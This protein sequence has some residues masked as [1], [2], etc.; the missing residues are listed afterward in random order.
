MAN[1]NRVHL[2][3]HCTRDPEIQ[4]T[5]KGTAVAELGLAINRVYTD[6]QG[7]KK[8]EATFVD[9]TLWG[10]L[11]GVAQQYLHKGSPIFIEGRLQ[12]DTWDDKQTGQKRSK[13]RVVG[14][15]LQLLGSKEAAAAQAPRSP[16]PD[17]AGR[18]PIPEPPRARRVPEPAPDIE[19]LF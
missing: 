9:V 8:E 15:S 19:P 11:A 5:P 4:Y 12:L 7:T 13:L 1:L 18:G 10:R 2:M 16:V 17:P 14:E 6:E 3:G